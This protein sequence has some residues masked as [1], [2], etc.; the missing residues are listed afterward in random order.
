[1]AETTYV[2]HH[3]Q[4]IALFLSAMRH[5]AEELGAKGGRIL[6]ARLDDPANTQ[7]IPGE[8]IRRASET[9]AKEVIATG[10]GEWRLVRALGEMP[11]PVTILPLQPALP[12]LPEPPPRAVRGEPADGAVVP[13]M[14]PDGRG[15][16]GTG[17]GRGGAVSGPDGGGGGGVTANAMRR[18]GR[19]GFT[20]P[21]CVRWRSWPQAR[22][23]GWRPDRAAGAA[24]RAGCCACPALR[25]WSPD[26]PFRSRRGPGSPLPQGPGR[27]RSACHRP[28]CRSRSGPWRSASCP[29]PDACRP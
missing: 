19:P 11:L 17:A 13:D 2:R 6:Y 20:R 27:T 1:M 23:P 7:S 3:P 14:G 18:H 12:A 28:S 29:V 24:P 16:P 10:P 25:D 22:K 21:G 8:L 5:F 15:A 9:G 26:P 4:K